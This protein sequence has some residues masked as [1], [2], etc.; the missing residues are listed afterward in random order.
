ML[1]VRKGGS[2][3]PSQYPYW[4]KK[5]TLSARSFRFVPWSSPWPPLNPYPPTYSNANTEYNNRVADDM[6]DHVSPSRYPAA[7]RSTPS[8]PES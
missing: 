1:A 4:N 8:S 7:Q 3:S 6:L 2:G 5:S